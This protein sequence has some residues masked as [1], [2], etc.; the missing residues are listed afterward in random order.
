MSFMLY[1]IPKQYEYFS[2]SVPNPEPF[3]ILC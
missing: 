1:L 2:I 3:S